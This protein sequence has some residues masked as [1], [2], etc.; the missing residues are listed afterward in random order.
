MSPFGDIL[1]LMAAM[2]WAVYSL[3]TRKLAV[4]GHG[5]LQTTRRIF[6]YGLI[7]MLPFVIHE[8]FH[9]EIGELVEP[10]NLLNM[11]FLGMGASAICF[12]TWT[13]TLRALGAVAASMYIYLV[14][15]VTIVTAAI[16]LHEP[17]TFTA[18][19]GICLVITG[20]V[21]A[22]KMGQSR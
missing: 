3:I 5:S 22:Q 2:A 17:L 16:I 18:F 12:A 10:T 14:P 13:F 4:A 19:A 7:F 8:G 6:F 21:I 1:A 11:L 9:V 20:L 15:V